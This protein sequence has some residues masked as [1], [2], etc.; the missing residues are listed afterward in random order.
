MLLYTQLDSEIGAHK[1]FPRQALNEELSISMSQV[2][3]ISKPANLAQ[4]CFF[5]S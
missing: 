2:S 4:N 3:S 5:S 1:L